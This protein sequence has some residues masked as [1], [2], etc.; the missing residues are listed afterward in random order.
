MTPWELA[1]RLK[2]EGEAVL[3]EL[4]PTDPFWIGASYAIDPFVGVIVH[5]PLN[6]PPVFGHGVDPA[7]FD[8]VARSILNGDLKG[9]PLVMVLEKFSRACR[10]DEW[11]RWYRPILAGQL[12][13]GIALAVF[14]EHCPDA[15]RVPPPALN[16][17][18]PI[19][20]LKTLPK[21]FIL[22]PLY[23]YERCFWMLNSKSSPPEIRGYDQ[24][25]RRLQNPEVE[26]A[27]ANF[28]KTTPVDVILTGF[29]ASDGFL[30]EDILTRDQF[31]RE[32]GAHPLA[33][34]LAALMKLNLRM[35]QV[36]DLLT[37]DSEQF[38]REL[39][40]LFE[41]RFDGAV[42]RDLDSHY[43]FRV[44]SDLIIHPRIK[45]VVTC[46]RVND[47]CIHGTQKRTNK[48]VK[49][50][51]RLGLT[52]TMWRDISSTSPV[53]RRFDILSCGVRDGEHLLPLF[54]KWRD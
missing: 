22:Q 4:P 39:D 23:P 20:S 1:A 9:D 26:A 44:Q 46:D 16:R 30:A 42:V 53:G 36:T 38:Y 13:L 15:Y 3:A 10:S 18:R 5:L 37:T 51:V 24:Q 45:A 49:A 48:A 47:Q 19:D 43:P 35:V 54:V 40:L 2:S 21:R 32:S 17:P 41:Q 29:L 52:N 7:I 8:Q 34:R 11:T 31:T 28:A 50:T 12:D 33:F 27:L 25:V 14:N 6:D